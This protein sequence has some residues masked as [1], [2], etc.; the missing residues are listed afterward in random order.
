MGFYSKESQKKNLGFGNFRA[1]HILY[2]RSLCYAVAKP[3]D[4]L[5][6]LTK[7]DY[8]EIDGRGFGY[9]RDEDLLIQAIEDNNLK[10]DSIIS[11]SYNSSEKKA[12][13]TTNEVREK[14]EIIY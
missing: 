9:F 7:Q 3:S 8:R 14:L 1:S 10:V 4:F 11:F 13:D 5:H 6:G 2:S 12:K